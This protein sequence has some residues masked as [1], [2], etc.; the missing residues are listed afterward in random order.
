M[1]TCECQTVRLRALEPGGA[2]GGGEGEQG[3]RR[4][5]RELSSRTFQYWEHFGGRQIKTT[6]TLKIENDLGW[7][8]YD[9][10]LEKSKINSVRMGNMNTELC[11]NN[12]T[13]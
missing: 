12:K 4:N 8:L 5:T 9:K 13:Y 3:R 10:V 1:L 11:K 7:N 2:G 6:N